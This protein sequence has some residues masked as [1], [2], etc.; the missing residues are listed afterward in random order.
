MRIGVDATCWA[1]ERGYGR[2]TRELCEAMVARARDDRFVFFADQRAADCFELAAPN[3]ELVRVE[4]SESPTEAAAA[5]RHRSV[6][7][8]LRMTRAVARVRPD[9]FFSPSVYTYFPVPPGQRSVVT[10]HDVIAE[11]FPHLTLPTLKS[12]LFWKAKVRLALWQAR[13]VLTVSEFSKR[14]IARVLGIEPARIHVACE[15]PAEGYT[16]STPAEIDA[17]RRRLGLP[18]G[19]SW[20]LYVGGFNP[21][22]NV[23][24]LIEALADLAKE[25]GRERAPHLLLVGTIDRDVFHGDQARIRG[26][27]EARA[28]PDLVHWTGFLEDGELRHL[29]SG[30]RALVLP[31]QCEGFGLPAVEAAACGTPVIATTESPLPELL[32]GAG[33]FVDPARPDE[34]LVALRDLATDPG[35]RDQLGGVALERAHALSWERGADAALAAL[36]EAAR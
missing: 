29:H 20:F 4:Q 28:C 3:A 9:V 33:R 1:N 15:A 12:R 11:R 8:M 7:D 26:T 25:L 21:H 13:V 30:A 24:R 16:P 18:D 34:L 17:A 36:R 14:D 27:I 19:A 5:H 23:D 35:L 10:V 31:S 32:A 6:R 2:F 22:K